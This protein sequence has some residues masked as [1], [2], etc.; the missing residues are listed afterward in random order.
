MDK[1]TISPDHYDFLAEE[2]DRFPWVILDHR[3]DNYPAMHGMYPNPNRAAHAMARFYATRGSDF[4][5]EYLVLVHFSD[6]IRG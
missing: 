1:F 2:A 5:A 3:D 4:A 6:L